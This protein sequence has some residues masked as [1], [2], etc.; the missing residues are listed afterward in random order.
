MADYTRT[1][2]AHGVTASNAARLN[3]IEAGINALDK[4]THA[5]MSDVTS[6]R[7]GDTL[8][9]NSSGKL[10]VVVIACQLASH[11]MLMAEVYDGSWRTCRID[12]GYHSGTS[13]MTITW[14]VP[15]GASYYANIRGTTSILSWIEVALH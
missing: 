1:T 5:S 15:N 8:Y 11:S 13:V 10:M 9:T 7:A 14:I 2:W 3:N 6:S 12:H 4:G